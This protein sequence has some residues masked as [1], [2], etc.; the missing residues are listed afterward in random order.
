MKQINPSQEKQTA[1]TKQSLTAVTLFLVCIGLAIT[2]FI[3]FSPALKNS[4]INWDDNYYVF[5]NNQLKQPLPDA[6]RYF[7]GQ[8]Y[9]IGNYIPLTMITYAIEFHASG[10]NPVTFHK[11]NII[12]HVL[13]VLLVFCF[14]FLLSDRKW[15]VASF[16]A[17]FFGVHPMHVESVAWV[18]ELKDVLY[19]FFFVLGLIFYLRY[20]A[21]E[22]RPVF[23]WLSLL[24]FSLSLL[25]KPAAI[26]FPL[27]ILLVDHYR[28]R[29]FD[30]RTWAE[31]IPFFALSV[32]FGLI[33][34]QAQKT[35]QLLLDD[36]VVGDKLLFASHSISA[37]LFNFFFP[38]QL[39]NFYPY[40]LREAGALPSE[41]YFAPILALA[42]IGA[43]IY[44]FR[45][46]RLVFFGVAFFMVNILLVLQ[47]I[48]VGFAI[49][50]DRYTYVAY[51]GLFFLIGMAGKT[52]AEKKGGA[53]KRA[54]LP[55]V[56]FLAIMAASLSYR[57]C[58]VW[59]NDESIAIDL[60]KKFPEDRLALNNM[61]FI[62]KVQENFDKAIPFFRKALAKKP[63]YIR[64]TVNLANTYLQLRQPQLALGVADTALFF[65]PGSDNLYNLRGDALFAMQDFMGAKNAYQE[66]LR[67]NNEMPNTW[68]RLAECYYKM[69]DLDNALK[70][71]DKVIKLDPF[72][73]QAFN[74]RG[75]VF[76]LMGNFEK[77]MENYRAS[78]NLNP[79]Y[80]VAEENIANLQRAKARKEY[81]PVK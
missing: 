34:L 2:T 17:L 52:Y 67:L 1:A 27:V 81:S 12:L 63:D 49:R 76:Y 22:P 23:P 78:L 24:F 54:I 37:Y 13:N 72:N 21:K 59:R 5:E 4:F 50:A 33:A 53:I 69:N 3:T 46:S 25:S 11:V 42:L 31:K 36:Y 75:F 9:F 14:I 55:G 71:L 39:A 56:I 80:R 7:F 40:P 70:N 65:S 19:T 62:Y 73:Y 74:S 35:D 29:K 79:G 38:I 41:F 30:M 47:L 18:A 45:K 20:V 26:V 51:I 43:G 6:I 58:K 77:A 61:G 44:F 60:L 10:L 8:H 15:D 32:A 68:M 28:N 48:S 16:V 57:R 64:A 66:A